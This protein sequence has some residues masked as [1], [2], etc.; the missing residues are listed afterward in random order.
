M[1]YAMRHQMETRVQAE[2]ELLLLDKDFVAYLDQ[3][4]VFVRFHPQ[5]GLVDKEDWIPLE[6]NQSI[7]REYCIRRASLLRLLGHI[8]LAEVA[9]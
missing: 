4:H 3:R 9:T 2:D 7:H 8:Q 1:R 5:K 6:I